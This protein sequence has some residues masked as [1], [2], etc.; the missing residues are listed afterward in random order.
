MQSSPSRDK[1]INRGSDLSLNFT[2]KTPRT[3]KNVRLQASSIKKLLQE[4]LSRA[5][6]AFKQ[7]VKGA[8]LAVHGA[9]ILR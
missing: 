4:N 3:I 7:T 8:C 5:D 9:A 6:K 1:S 2:L